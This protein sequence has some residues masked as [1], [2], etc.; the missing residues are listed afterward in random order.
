MKKLWP[1]SSARKWR[2]PAT[3]K[4]RRRRRGEDSGE[5]RKDQEKG[6]EARENVPDHEPHL[7]VT[8]VPKDPV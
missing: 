3:R 8:I 6:G 7:G 2:R 1:T 4:W 5:E